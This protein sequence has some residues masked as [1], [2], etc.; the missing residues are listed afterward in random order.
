MGVGV[1]REGGV[2]IEGGVHALS[3]ETTLLIR[4]TIIHA[5]PR[6]EYY[7]VQYVHGSDL[8]LPVEKTKQQRASPP[9]HPPPWCSVSKGIRGQWS[10]DEGKQRT[11]PPPPPPPADTSAQPLP[12]SCAT[13][14][15]EKS[16]PDTPAVAENR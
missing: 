12:L 4:F 14:A 6:G 16:S 3:L 13:L 8:S 10:N 11:S 5:S 1:E 15:R 7:T 9:P 2:N